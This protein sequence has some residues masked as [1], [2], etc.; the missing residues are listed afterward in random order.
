MTGGLDDLW[1]E[2]LKFNARWWPDWRACPEI[3][4]SNAYAGEVGEIC[5]AT[6]HRAGG[7]THRVSVSDEELAEEL[8]DAFIYHVLLAERIGIDRNAFK[9]ALRRKILLNEERMRQAR[10]DADGSPYGQQ[11]IGGEN[12]T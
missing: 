7:G 1:T 10:Y 9:Q 8:A 2:L 12:E 6:K 3:E 11:P 5:N 4:L